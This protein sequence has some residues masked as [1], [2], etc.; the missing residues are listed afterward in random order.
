V[1]QLQPTDFKYIFEKQNAPHART[2]HTTP[3][4]GVCVCGA[5]RVR[6]A[7]LG[8][9]CL[10]NA[11]QWA[12]MALHCRLSLGLSGVQQGADSFP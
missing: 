10:V 12:A 8:A 3:Y 4:K 7:G 6:G 9:G 1:R 11:L 2:P 5:V